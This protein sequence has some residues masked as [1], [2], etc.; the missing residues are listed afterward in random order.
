MMIK[1][2]AFAINPVPLRAPSTRAPRLSLAQRYGGRPIH[3]TGTAIVSA[4]AQASVNNQALH[5]PTAEPVEISHIKFSYLMPQVYAGGGSPNQGLGMDGGGLQ[6]KIGINDDIITNGFVP[7]WCF[8]K[9]INLTNEQ[10]TGTDLANGNVNLYGEFI[11]E[12]PRKLYLRPADQITAAFSNQGQQ[13]S[14]LTARI[15]LSG[16][17]LPQGKDPKTRILPYVTSYVGKQFV[18]T[19]A[20]SDESNEQQLVNYTN[21]QLNLTK[22]IGRLDVFVSSGAVHTDGLGFSA[23]GEV[24]DDFGQQFLSVLALTGKGKPLI[25]YATT[26]RLAFCGA[27]RVWNLNGELDPSDY[28]ILSLAKAGSSTPGLYVQAQVGMVGWRE[29][30]VE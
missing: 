4:N 2:A 18:T 7:V 5:V 14:S 16:V 15:S 29:V 25:P 12:L 20:D 1:K 28:I 10:L 27:D 17:V 26:Y 6:V 3:L 13:A 19:S 23:A 11:W 24:N 22:L 9:A 30:P 8:D 21:Q